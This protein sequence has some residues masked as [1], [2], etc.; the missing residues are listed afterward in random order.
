MHNQMES[1]FS[2]KVKYP[3]TKLESMEC[4]SRSFPDVTAAA[5]VCEYLHISKVTSSCLRHN[6]REL[7]HLLAGTDDRTQVSMYPASSTNATVSD[8]NFPSRGLINKV[9]LLVS[10]TETIATESFAP[11]VAAAV[12]FSPAQ[13][14]AAAPFT[15][16]RIYQ[17]IYVLF[18]LCI[19]LVCG[20]RVTSGGVN[21]GWLRRS[22]GM[23]LF[24]T[25]STCATADSEKGLEGINLSSDQTKLRFTANTGGFLLLKY[26]LLCN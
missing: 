14:P 19:N 7:C 23:L 9:E 12:V 4:V 5:K 16:K 15:G 20:F 2:K 26:S 1:L 10:Q 24:P 8:D 6:N 13:K 3:G 18:I 11:I 17:Q 22:P 25:G 21:S